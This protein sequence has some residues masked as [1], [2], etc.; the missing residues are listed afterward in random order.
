MSVPFLPWLATVCNVNRRTKTRLLLLAVGV[1][2]AAAAAVGGYWVLH[3]QHQSRIDQNLGRHGPI[4]WKHA[5]ANALPSELIRDIVRA[6]SGGD[7]RAVSPRS[8]KGLMQITPIALAEVRRRTDIGEG[9]LFDPDYNVRVGT[10]YFRMMVER[11]DGDAYLALAAY[12]MGPTRLRSLCRENPG[13][14]GRQVVERFAPTETKAYCRK[15]LR[16]KDLRI[17]SASRD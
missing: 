9:D 6:E 11:F 7:E 16:G 8:A 5:R 17:P 2:L 14:T 3:W 15:I 4:I 1:A 13:L 12:N 10:A